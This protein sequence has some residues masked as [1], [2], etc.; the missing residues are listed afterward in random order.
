M[1]ECCQVNG[2]FKI[3][4]LS[5]N[6]TYSFYVQAGFFVNFNLNR[7]LVI[8]MRNCYKNGYFDRKSRTREVNGLKYMNMKY[9][10]GQV[11]W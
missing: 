10:R 7:L 8:C 4:F 3:V 9:Q 11:T 1:I 5:L 6:R 2:S